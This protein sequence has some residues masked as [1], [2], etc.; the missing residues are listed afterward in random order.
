MTIV[1]ASE[2]LAQERGTE[3]VEE[4]DLVK[5]AKTKTPARSRQCML[6]SLSEIRINIEAA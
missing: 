5:V 4:R 3:V 1:E 2:A 6:D